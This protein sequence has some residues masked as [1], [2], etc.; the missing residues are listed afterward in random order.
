MATPTGARLQ[1]MGAVLVFAGAPQV[2]AHALPVT[3][4]AKQMIKKELIHVKCQAAT[5]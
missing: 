1:H 2:Q 4:C 5:C 3:A